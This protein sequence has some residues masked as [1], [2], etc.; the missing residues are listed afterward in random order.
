M[1]NRERILAVLD[2]KPPDRIPFAP[3]IALW[4]NARIATDTMPTK[5][6]GMSLREVERELGIGTPAR[7]GRVFSIRVE[8]VETV[9]RDEG[10][11]RITE[12]HTPV[13]MI[14][15]STHYSDDLKERG[16]GGREEEFLLKG[17]KDY[18]VWEY[19]WE[20]TYWDPEYEAYEEYDA[21]IGDE[22]M[23]M[24]GV[25]DAPFHHYE[26]RGPGYSNAFYHV[27]D[28]PDEVD[29]LMA[30]MTEV[31]RERQWPVI[32]ESPARMILHGVHHSSA[33]TP[34]PIY[35]KYI[36]PYYEAFM[37]VM[38]EHGK[39]VAMHADNDTSLILG[40]L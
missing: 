17:A 11:S 5:F 27:A 31:Q 6:K 2:G 37:P 40:Q 28:Y 10:G 21:D 9:H 18:A 3:R 14:R 15:S 34:P 4:Y 13:G 7:N 16:M 25:G 23:P 30:V 38:H 24:V 39:S 12:H 8:D 19:M 29:H 33:F 35:E 26:L 36:L 20:H 22:G 32:A 1:N